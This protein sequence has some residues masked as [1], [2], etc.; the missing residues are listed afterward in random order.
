MASCLTR[1]FD[2]LCIPIGKSGRPLGQK[3]VADALYPSNAAF[4]WPTCTHCEKHIMN[5][6]KLPHSG[7]TL[8]E[9]LIVLVLIGMVTALVGPRLFKNLAESKPKVAATQIKMLR[10]AVETM[11][12]DIGRYP[13]KQEGLA[14]LNQRPSDASSA[15]KWKGPYLD[16]ALPAD[17]WGHPYQY[18]IPGS[19]GHPFALYSLGS[20]HATGGEGDAQDV[21]ILP[22]Q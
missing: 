14:L 11:N 15:A 8:M 9:M 13:N 22:P 20:D 17:P 1:Q 10:G 6:Q 2:L 3:S 12:L 5:C 21:G 16:D 18:A 4:D 7:F 19:D